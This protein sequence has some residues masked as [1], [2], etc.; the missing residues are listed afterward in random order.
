MIY[1]IYLS[2]LIYSSKSRRNIVKCVLDIT[3]LP[4]PIKIGHKLIINSPIEFEFI[5]YNINSFSNYLAHRRAIKANITKK[6]NIKEFLKKFYYYDNNSKKNYY[7]DKD[8]KFYEI[9]YKS[10]I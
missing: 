1:T 9:N 8:L 6:N 7:S 4:K 3:Q 10:T 5:L 2:D